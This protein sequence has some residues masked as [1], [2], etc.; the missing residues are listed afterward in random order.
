VNTATTG[1]DFSGSLT[2]QGYNLFGNIS[3]M[4]FTPTTGDQTNIVDPK[5]GPLQNNGGPTFTHAL[6]SG[7]TAIDGGN[8]SGIFASSISLLPLS[9]PLLPG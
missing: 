6:L 2:S 4:T 1:P 8:S 9:S 5:L 7:S 3:G